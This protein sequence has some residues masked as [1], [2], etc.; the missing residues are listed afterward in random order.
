MKLHLVL[1]V[2]V[3]LDF[4]STSGV[5][6]G[7]VILKTLSR[8]RRSKEDD[9]KACEAACPRE[10]N[11]RCEPR[12]GTLEIVSSMCEYECQVK[13]LGKGRLSK[14]PAF[15]SFIK[16][17]GNSPVK[18]VTG[19]SLCIFDGSLMENE[20]KSDRSHIIFLANGLK[21]P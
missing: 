19:I 8:G 16:N 6:G 10:K 15:S 11:I 14:F 5:L 3:L 1:V 9:S 12:S 21:I 20:T 18:N 13:F 4:L 7:G 2:V 17:N